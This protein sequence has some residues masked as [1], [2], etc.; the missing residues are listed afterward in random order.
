MGPAWLCVVWQYPECL[1]EAIR[2][3]PDE[4]DLMGQAARQD[5]ANGCLI[6]T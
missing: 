5:I 2:R 1:Q 3:E 6:L 4:S